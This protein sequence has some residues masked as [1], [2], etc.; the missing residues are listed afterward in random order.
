[1][2]IFF[3]SEIRGNLQENQ[4]NQEKMFAIMKSLAPPENTFD[5][6][7]EEGYQESANATTQLVVQSET[8]K[9]LAEIQRQLQSLTSD[10]KTNGT[11]PTGRKR[12]N[13][14]T[15]NDAALTRSNV[16]KY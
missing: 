9:V 4:E 6:N 10:S 1:M 13:R 15:P 3:A 12:S 8:L 2:H 14:K 7:Y 16:G 11:S 5:G